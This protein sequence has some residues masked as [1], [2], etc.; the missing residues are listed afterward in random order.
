MKEK[1]YIFVQV[2]LVPLYTVKIEFQA[3]WRSILF[4]SS[5]V[6]RS[7]VVAPCKK[8]NFFFQYVFAVS[9]K[10][11]QSLKFQTQSALANS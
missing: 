7:L 10:S 6:V 3:H 9:Q 11:E 1:M 4:L 5:A 8:K 2:S